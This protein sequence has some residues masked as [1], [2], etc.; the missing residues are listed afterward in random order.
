M[1]TAT[2][3]NPPAVPGG[4]GA[5]TPR[6]DGPL[7]VTGMARYASDMAV[8]NAAYAYFHTSAIA[9]GRITEIDE[10]EARA[11]PGIIDIL[12][13][14]NAAGQFDP[15]KIFSAG[16]TASTSIMPLQS[17]DIRHDGEIVAVILAESLDAARDASH[18]LRV[19]Y[20]ARRPTATFDDPGL[21]ASDPPVGDPR[22]VDINVGDAEGAFAAGV[23]RV[24]ARYATPI[25]HHNPMELFTTTAQWM[26]DELEIYEPS[27]YIVGMQHGIATQ[28]RH[29]PAKTRFVS[30]YVGGAFGSK[31]AITPRTALIAL[32]ARRLNR[33]VKFVSTRDQAFTMATHRAE[34]RHRVRLAADADGRFT[35]LIHEGEEVTSRPDNYVVAGTDVTTRMYAVPNIASH[36]T[37]QHA[38]RDTPGFM[39]APAEVPYLFALES[40]VDE[41][42]LALDMDPVELRRI[43]DTK[44]DPVAGRPFSSRS[45][46]Q[47]YDAAAAAFGWR[48]RDPRPMSMAEGDWQIGWGCASAVYPSYIAPSFARVTLSRDGARVDVAGHELGT[49]AYTVYAQIAAE[50]LGLPLDRVEVR[51]GDS[52]LPPAPVAGGSNNAASIGT[53]VALGCA[54]VRE[55]LATAAVADAASPLHG[56]DASELHLEDG[57]LRVSDGPSEPVS[58]GLSRHGGMIEMLAGSE[59]AN[60]QPGSL[61]A[62]STGQA[63]LGGAT[64]DPGFTKM[65]FGAEFVEV[66]VH[67]RTREVRVERIVGAFA[68]GRILN[69]MTARSQ[70]LGGMIWGIGSALHE[71][72]EIDQRVARYTNDNLAEYLVPVNADIKN[73]EVI[74]VPEVDLEVN[75]LGV[76]GIGELGGVGTN[77]AICNAIY[78]ATGVRIRD[79]PV[80]IEKL[81]G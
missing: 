11:L 2:V 30:H 69:P 67:R 4:I 72:T 23:V 13:W 27:Q 71:A 62:L 36:V 56:L 45:L 15:L 33:P 48:G 26:G 22:F 16:G 80:R 5:A 68:G 8:A 12:T 42:A 25:Q 64:F 58:K 32:A 50:R 66:R 9:L 52:R 14:R 19:R 43:N 54:M 34:T 40:A 73:V 59:P 81:L 75:P 47:C 21:V 1:T 53:A 20:D 76:K 3:P 39:R 78:H 55:R 28:M 17:P 44:T 63:A 79:L 77:A 7:K 49:G 18:R 65:A 74:F 70:L 29:D 46:M 31:G 24:D 10:G 6:I 60:L 61:A 35:A 37:V 51:M 57:V 38:D 41:L